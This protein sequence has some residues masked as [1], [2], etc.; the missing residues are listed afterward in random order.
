MT[1]ISF[2]NVENEKEMIQ[3]AINSCP[4]FAYKTAKFVRGAD[5]SDSLHIFY[6]ND[7][8]DAMWFRLHWQ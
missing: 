1:P 6:F 3:W 5:G 7:E 4:T 2:L 8:K